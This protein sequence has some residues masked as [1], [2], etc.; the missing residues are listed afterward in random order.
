MLDLCWS[1]AGLMMASQ[2]CA[3]IGL[4]DKTPLAQYWLVSADIGPALA[5]WRC[6]IWEEYIFQSGAPDLFVDL[7]MHQYNCTHTFELWLIN[8]HSQ[9]K[10]CFTGVFHTDNWRKFK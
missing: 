3:N 2:H 9:A 5:Q 4:L 6:A 8:Y 7:P 1:N 10:T